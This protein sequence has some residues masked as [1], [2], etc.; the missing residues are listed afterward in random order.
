SKENRP[1][2]R[3]VSVSSEACLSEL[4]DCN[5]CQVALGRRTCS[6]RRSGGSGSSARFAGLGGLLHRLLHLLES[7]HLDLSDSFARHPELR[8]QV[9]ERHRLVRQAASLEDAALALI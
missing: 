4:A 5:A 8:R 3:P 9:L 2:V 6:T 7:A 1:Q